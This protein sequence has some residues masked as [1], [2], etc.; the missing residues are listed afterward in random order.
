MLAANLAFLRRSGSYPE[1][2]LL[3]APVAA[4]FPWQ[5]T[6]VA[7]SM[8]GHPPPG[9]GSASRVQLLLRQWPPA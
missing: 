6:A 5:S 1:K 2:P 3:F 8:V 9:G 7:C 4:V